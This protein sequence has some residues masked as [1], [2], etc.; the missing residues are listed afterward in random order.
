MLVRSILETTIKFH[1]ESTNT[2]ATGQLN[3]SVKVLA[4]A[5]GSEKATKQQINTIKSG[6][7]SKPGS[8]QWF[9]VVTHG[10]NQVVKDEE[11]R[12]AW[13]VVSPVL[14]RLLV[15]PAKTSV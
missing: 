10:V 4:D 7:A 13:E 3:E 2:P 6:N 9:N 12:E 8:V 14:R 15:L 1:F 5:Y 11:V